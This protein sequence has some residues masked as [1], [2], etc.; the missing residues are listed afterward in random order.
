MV[1]SVSKKQWECLD[2]ISAGERS[3]YPGL[4]MATLGALERKGLVHA[5]RGLG[6][7]AFPHTAIKWSLTTAGV[8]AIQAHIARCSSQVEQP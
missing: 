8:A 2:S 4:S 5:K 7:M 6:S 1:T 3:A